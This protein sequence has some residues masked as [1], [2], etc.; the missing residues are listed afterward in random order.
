MVDRHP[1]SSTG[2]VATRPVVYRKHSGPHLARRILRDV[3]NHPNNR[4]HRAVAIGRAVAWQLRKRLVRK[5]RTRKVFGSMRIWM[6]PHSGSASN[7]LYFGDRFDLDEMTFMER[8]LQPGDHFV[9]VGANIGTY[10]LLAAALVGPTG[11]VDAFE[12][13]PHLVRSLRANVALNDLDPS[14]CVHEMA[15][16]DADGSIPFRVD[17][18]VSSRI[19][20]ESD[21]TSAV[22]LVRCDRLDAQ[23]PDGPVAMAKIDVEG[24][25]HAVL[26]GFAEHLETMNP[27]V[28]MLEV[29]AN[30]LERQGTSVAEVVGFLADAGYDLAR[31][32][33]ERAELQWLDGTG[34]K[35]NLLAVS[36]GARN[37]VFERMATAPVIVDAHGLPTTHAIGRHAALHRTIA[38]TRASGDSDPRTRTRSPRR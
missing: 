1:E 18:D 31:Y 33:A 22:V 34:A 3:W 24:A 32:S 19:A 23:L 14:V 29:F 15:A 35:G 2:D 28:L 37:V 9:D 36:R 5:L 12:A 38:G 27:P 21:P 30:Q 8:Y 25:E 13:A 11:R 10:T 17:L 16:S 7:I 4:G 6:D 26:R 20:V